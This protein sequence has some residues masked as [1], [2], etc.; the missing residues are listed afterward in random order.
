MGY[1]HRVRPP[2]AQSAKVSFLELS[3]LNHPLEI[4]Q[5]RVFPPSREDHV[6]DSG[7]IFQYIFYDG[8]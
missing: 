8:K 5:V 4:E 7:T 3:L 2:L 1:L 6:F